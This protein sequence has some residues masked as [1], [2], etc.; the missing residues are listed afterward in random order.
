MEFHLPPFW[1]T[2]ILNIHVYDFLLTDVL[3]CEG[4]AVDWV[5]RNLFWTD[6]RRKAISVAS[7]E[8]P[9]ERKILIEKHLVHPRAITLDPRHGRGKG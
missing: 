1:V 2:T 6:E 3:N 5:G 4:L 8:N 9:N 7:L